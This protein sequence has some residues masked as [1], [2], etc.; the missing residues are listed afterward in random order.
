MRTIKSGMRMNK[1]KKNKAI[2]NIGLY[3]CMII[4]CI[5]SLIRVGYN[6]FPVT[7]IILNLIGI[8]IYGYDL[9][10]LNP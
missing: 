3:I 1:M 8:I 10:K 6:I 4:V 5:S 7:I 9:Y 2:L